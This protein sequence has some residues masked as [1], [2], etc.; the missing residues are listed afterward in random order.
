MGVILVGSQR[1]WVTE[2]FSELICT[3]ASWLVVVVVVVLT[4]L[5]ATSSCRVRISRGVIYHYFLLLTSVT[6]F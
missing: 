2:I 6:P 1:K 3:G 5:V 4:I